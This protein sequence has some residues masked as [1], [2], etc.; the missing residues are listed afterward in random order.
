M[1]VVVRVM[2]ILLL[3]LAPN[4]LQTSDLPIP[5]GINKPMKKIKIGK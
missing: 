4:I 5:G 2:T 1:L 3:I